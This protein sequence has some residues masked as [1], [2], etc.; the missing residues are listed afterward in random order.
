MGKVF[1]KKAKY[2]VIDN[3]DYLFDMSAEELTELLKKEQDKLRE[4]SQSI[5]KDSLK[6]T[7][8]LTYLMLFNFVLLFAASVSFFP[9]L[10][11]FILAFVGLG[12]GFIGIKKIKEDILSN[13]RR[14]CA[15]ISD[16]IYRQFSEYDK[17]DKLVEK[18]RSVLNAKEI[19]NILFGGAP[20]DSNKGKD[21]NNVIDTVR[22]GEIVYESEE[23]IEDED[24]FGFQKVKTF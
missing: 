22:V 14:Y 15:K 6:L 11:N 3:Y 2:E 4:L 17:S 10:D 20:S 24:T 7:R 1:K 23:P 16:K 12:T 13:P 5:D 18:I 21:K 19:E 9:F 8:I